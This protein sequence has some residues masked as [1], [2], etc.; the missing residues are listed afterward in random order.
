MFKALIVLAL[1][2]TLKVPT[3]VTRRVEILLSHLKIGSSG[4]GAF[5]FANHHPT[6]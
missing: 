3:V 5:N 6:A 1:P 2:F 4:A